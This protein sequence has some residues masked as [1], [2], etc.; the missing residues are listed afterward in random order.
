[1]QQIPEIISTEKSRREKKAKSVQ[2]QRKTLNG[3]N[4]EKNGSNGS[5]PSA[6]AVNRKGFWQIKN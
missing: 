5:K 1:M 2:N 6:V 3:K 4:S